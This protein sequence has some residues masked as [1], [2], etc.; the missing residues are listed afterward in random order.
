MLVA[1]GL[2]D[3]LNCCVWAL[4]LAGSADEALTEVYNLGFAVNDFKH[5]YRARVFARST[6]VTLVV[7]NFDFNHD[8][9]P[10]YF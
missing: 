3:Y 10:L 4:N 5:S 6:T 8:S 1:F 7:V 9:A 2:F